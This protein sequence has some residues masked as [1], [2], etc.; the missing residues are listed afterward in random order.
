MHNPARYGFVPA[1][2]GVGD[3]QLDGLP[4]KK[5]IVGFNKNATAADIFDHA[6][7]LLVTAGEKHGFK[8]GLAW[9]LAWV[10]IAFDAAAFSGRP[11]RV[12]LGV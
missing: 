2:S 5:I 7:T 8:T 10:R 1:D 11:F 9:I 6:C 12:G 3:D 4:E